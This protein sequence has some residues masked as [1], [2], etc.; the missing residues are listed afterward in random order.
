ML[1][2]D[3]GE[4]HT[5]RVTT[6]ITWDMNTGK[7]L[8]HEYFEYEGPVAR[9]DRA[10][11][12][13]A[14][15][16]YKQSLGIA[17]QQGQEAQAEQNQ[18]MPF[19]S[20]EMKERHGFTPDQ[21]GEILTNEESGIGGAAAGADEEARLHA[22]RTRNASG[23]TKALDENARNK[24]KA[25][26]GAAGSAAVQDVMKA[27]QDNQAG[28]AGIAGMAGENLSA[29]EKALGM[30]SQAIQDELAA[31]KTG[32]LQNMN[33]TITALSGAATGAANVKKAF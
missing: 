7:V 9:L 15:S 24:M 4:N 33:D 27:K 6:K 11:N 8:E 12:S 5:M 32:W 29:Q 13:Q 16:V 30:E 26:S 22:A 1:E 18:V 25:A 21:F 20:S 10:A 17:N 19:F 31:D 23:F 2:Q 14:N 28:A 3:H